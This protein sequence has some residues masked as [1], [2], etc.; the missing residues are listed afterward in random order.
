MTTLVFPFS[1]FVAC[2]W[3]VVVDDRTWGT[4]EVV[5]GDTWSSREGVVDHEGAWA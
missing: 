5:E 2:A 1:S 4:C 3:V